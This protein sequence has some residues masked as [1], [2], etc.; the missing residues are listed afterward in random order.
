MPL[1]TQIVHI[2]PVLNDSIEVLKQNLKN[3]KEYEETEED[4]KVY[5]AKQDKEEAKE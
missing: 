2:M 4:K 3:W 1:F 5:E